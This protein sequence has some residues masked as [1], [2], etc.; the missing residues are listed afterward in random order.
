MALKLR[1]AEAK[2]IPQST[3]AASFKR[4]LGRALVA[5]QSDSRDTNRQTNRTRP[6]SEESKEAW[7]DGI[8]IGIG[9]QPDHSGH[10]D[11]DQR[12]AAKDEETEADANPAGLQILSHEVS[13]VRASG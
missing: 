5:A 12:P 11:E 4:L 13:A 7:T 10:D 2:L 9:P 1:R 6:E 3:R 8:R